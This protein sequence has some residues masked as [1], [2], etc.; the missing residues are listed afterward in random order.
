M[1]RALVAVWIGAGLLVATPVWAGGDWNDEGIAW[2]PYET[3]FA[4]AKQEGKPLC[5][6]VYTDWCPHCTNYSKVFHDEQIGVLSRDFVMVRVDQGNA[7]RIA[8][9]HAPDGAYIP[10]TLFF[11]PDG[12]LDPDIRA[13]RTKYV[14]FFDE[15]DPKQ[16]AGAMATAREK[17]V[18]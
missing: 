10:R 9:K 16:L 8:K 2:R 11:S 7:E 15:H 14:H 13:P 18:R 6:V 1:M 4:E 5:M 17:H 3:A 12:A